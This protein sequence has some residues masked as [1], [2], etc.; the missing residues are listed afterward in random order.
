MSNALLL[1]KWLFRMVRD[2]VWLGHANR[3]WALSLAM[4]L[5]LLVGLVVIGA[6]VS[7]PF[8]YTLF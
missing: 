3:T 6:Q 1:F 8:I 5:L 2:I 4:L 7:A